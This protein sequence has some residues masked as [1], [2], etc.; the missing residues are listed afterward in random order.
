MSTSA[1]HKR[2][3]RSF[4]RRTGRKTPAQE[5]AL[6]TLWVRYGVDHSAEALDFATLFDRQASVV[7]EIGFG[8]GDALVDQAR[9][10]PDRDYLG[11]E[12]HLPGIG[13][14]LLR[15][16][17]E[18]ISNLRVIA[19]DAI[20]VLQNRIADGSID[21]VNLYFPDPWPKK[22]HHKRRLIQS[23]FLRQVATKLRP[24]GDFFVATDWFDYAEHIDEV[25]DVERCFAVI[26][27][28]EHAADAPMDRVNTRFERR[29]IGKG[30]AIWDWHLRRV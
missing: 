1:S 21:R 9:H 23:D 10:H 2:T 16:E 4:V 19:D 6:E 24:D 7:L 26:E 14:C 30:H 12:V 27:R 8:N 5:R 20:D 13:H 3:I 28:R 15:A 29:G 22:R 11:V 18:D 25:L 17:Q